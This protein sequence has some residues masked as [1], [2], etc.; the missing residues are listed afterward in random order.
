MTVLN[1]LT[2]EELVELAALDLYGL[3][4]D[5]ESTLF[6]RS[7]HHAPAAV[8]KE[9]LELQED[10][11]TDVSLLTDEEPPPELRQ[12]VLDSVAAAMENESTE[13]APL[14]TI[15][16][17]GKLV[18]EAV[19]RIS[20]N[21]SRHFWRAA[22]FALAGA[23]L[24]MAYFYAE[25]QRHSTDIVN[26]VTHNELMQ[27]EA[28]LGPRMTSYLLDQSS[29]IAMKPTNVN[30]RGSGAVFF[31]ETASSLCVMHRLPD[32]DYTLRVVFEDGTT[33][34]VNGFKGNGEENLGVTSAMDLTFALSAVTR[35][36]IVNAAGAVLLTSA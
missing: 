28:I 27:I 23:V 11:A 8:Q 17:S 10:L 6:T 14:A 12:R 35:W 16:G 20:S 24:V 1:P 21:G 7:L 33:Q 30:A 3:L 13:L 31:N 15:G 2:R 25:A 32:E 34:V 26:L 18:R 19:G 29:K 4:E 36:E 9:I 22:T 5:Y